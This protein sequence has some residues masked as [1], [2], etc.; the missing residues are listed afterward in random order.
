MLLCYA[1]TR[2]AQHLNKEDILNQ[3]ATFIPSAPVEEHYIIL[4][5]FNAHVVHGCVEVN[6]AGPDLLSFC[7]V[8]RPLYI[9]NTW[10]KKAVC[11]QTWQHPKSKKWKLYRFCCNEPV[12]KVM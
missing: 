3:L 1:P 8:M 7:P 10:F 5:D 6:D 9:C 12:R 11:Q 4:G 2:A